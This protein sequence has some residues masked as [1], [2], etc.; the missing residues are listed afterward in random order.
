VV[1]SGAA[2]VVSFCF[3]SWGLCSALCVCARCVCAAVRFRVIVF[4]VL[5]PC[6]YYYRDVLVVP[7][8]QARA[9]PNVSPFA[10]SCSSGSAEIGAS[11]V[12]EC[13]AASVVSLCFASWGLCSSV[14]AHCCAVPRHCFRRGGGGVLFIF[15]AVF[16]C[17][18][19]TV[20]LVL[21]T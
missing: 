16:P 20:N 9:A 11:E 5:F 21:L 1:E 13:G 4:V 15:L 8:L 10:G 3:A 19:S 12:V 6:S 2:A 17:C 14:C 18:H 7:A